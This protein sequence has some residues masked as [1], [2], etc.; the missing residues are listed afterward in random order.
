MSQG[1]A[2]FDRLIT[3]SVEVFERVWPLIRGAPHNRLAW[4][5]TAAG[6]LVIAGPWWE[7]PARALIA[8]YLDVQIESTTSPGW[9]FALVVVGLAYHLLAY[10]ADALRKELADKR[11]R[12]HDAPMMRE[13]QSTF[14]EQKIKS[15]LGTIAADHSIYNSEQD[16]LDL[17]TD[18]LRSPDFYLVDAVVRDRARALA[19]AIQQLSHF[20][21]SEFF[22]P[23]GATTQSRTCLQPDLNIDRSGTHMPTADESARYDTLGSELIDRVRRVKAAYANMIRAAHEHIL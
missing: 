3:R 8:K 22:V 20:V 15:I 1:F 4:M 12:D 21:G 18:R 11:I 2:V 10:R 5:V 23:M 17:M 7:T 14:P 16:F 6:V 9:G 13:F 19:E